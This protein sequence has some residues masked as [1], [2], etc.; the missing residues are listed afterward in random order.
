MNNRPRI[1]LEKTVYD[2]ALDYGAFLALALST[3][4]AIYAFNALPDSIPV[5]YDASGTPTR[6]G[7]RFSLFTLPVV[8]FILY[9]G[10]IVLNKRP[11]IF[12][13]T[14]EITPE[15]AKNQYTLACK[16]MRLVNFA[17]SLGISFIIYETVKSSLTGD[18]SLGVWFL[19]VFLMGM[20]LPIIYYFVK[21]KD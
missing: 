16:V 3:F 1:N 12:N 18:F 14:V 17:M 6:F 7:S 5:H 11:D 15:N 21:L 13:Y 8:G 2:Y 10:F 9:F 4:Y 19:P 20:F